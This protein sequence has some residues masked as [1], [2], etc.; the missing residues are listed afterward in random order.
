[1]KLPTVAPETL[2][3]GEL[4][5]IEQK[6]GKNGFQALQAIDSDEPAAPVLAAFGAVLLR[7]ARADLTVKQAYDRAGDLTFG[8]ITA[9][10]TGDT[11]EDAEDANTAED[12]EDAEDAEGVPAPP[13]VLPADHPAAL[14]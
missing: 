10:L 6:T 3:I 13:R 12:A 2:T 5:F 9:A 1:M 7:R 11:A 4:D 8:E 14:G